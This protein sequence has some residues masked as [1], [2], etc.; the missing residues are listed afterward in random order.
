[1]GKSSD[2][3]VARRAFT[4]A[5]PAPLI[6]FGDPAREDRTVRLES[7]SNDFEAEPVEPGEG[8][9][10]GAAEAD[11]RGSVGH[12]EVFKMASV[13]TSIFGRPR[14]LPRTDAPARP[15]PSSGKSL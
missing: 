11:R 5:T 12:V 2:H 9:Q 13:R 6:G 15:T 3:A 7:L 14:L 10:V 8:G 4:T 1:V